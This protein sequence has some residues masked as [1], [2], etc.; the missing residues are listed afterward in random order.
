MKI[1]LILLAIIAKTSHSTQVNSTI[2]IATFVLC[3]M[4]WILGNSITKLD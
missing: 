4:K 1:S 3:W 2:I